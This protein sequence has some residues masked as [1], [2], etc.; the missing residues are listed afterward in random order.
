MVKKL[1][2]GRIFVLLVC[3]LLITVVSLS[4][5]AAVSSNTYSNT[6]WP[7]NYVPG[8]LLV[9]ME[10]PLSPVNTS[11]FPNLE[12][13]SIRDLTDVSAF[14]PFGATG[15]Y[16]GRQIL[17]IELTEN[18]E[19]AMQEALVLLESNS[20]VAYAE[21]NIF[22]TAYAGAHNAYTASQW[23]LEQIQADLAW[24]ITTGSSGVV[25]GVLD[26]GIDQ[27]HSALSGNVN[28]ALGYN[29][30][31]NNPYWWYETADPLDDFG[32]GTHVGGILGATGGNDEGVVGL[33]Q[34]LTIVPLKIFDGGGNGS[35]A[36][37]IA[38]LAYAAALEIPIV[39]LSGGWYGG[40][41]FTAMREAVEAYSG[42]IVA[43][44][45]NGGNDNDDP[46]TAVYPASFDCANIIS[47]A[48]SNQEDQLCEFSGY[49]AL[50]VDVA[51]P[52]QD[53]FSTVDYWLW[54]YEEGWYTEPGYEAWSGVSMAAAHVTGTAALLKAADPGLSTAQIKT[55]I[56]NNT[57]P[58]PELSGLV[59]T[60]GRL[61]AYAALSSLGQASQ[62][63][64]T[65]IT[66]NHSGYYAV[67]PASGNTTLTVTAQI[68]DQYGEIMNGYAPVYAVENPYSGVSVDNATGLITVSSGTA[69]GTINIVASYDNLSP[70]TVELILSEYEYTAYLNTVTSS[71][72]AGETFEV[73]LM[74]VG[75]INYTQIQAEIIFDD[76]LLAYEGYENLHGWVA[77]CAPSAPDTV[78]VRSVPSTNA[79]IG[80]PCLPAVRIVTLKFSV[81]D[82]F[83][84]ENVESELSFGSIDVFSPGGYIGATTAPGQAISIILNQPL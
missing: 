62:L 72:L 50:A 56:L 71:L 60:N 75:A 1:F 12:I 37:L 69:A 31:Y 2:G 21:P 16:S 33:N 17:L 27:S 49:G 70:V 20:A 46:A 61:N 53:I 29:F 63:Q 66:F 59:L 47:V 8:Q 11:L 34:Q 84:D 79:V 9:G 58:S 45:G 35:E 24:D 74:L 77:A 42:L 19:T 41:E 36:E 55:A 30:L 51:A 3:F 67:I 15:S 32:H 57:D 6:P 25:V 73:E 4:V 48:A 68:K 10:T 64:P 18:S 22:G 39:N 83:N 13:D 82:S 52:G 38:A 40:G 54:D 65:N 80:E 5:N 43:A 78:T 44:A 23:N 81:L 14:L 28:A 26:S 76:G 7:E